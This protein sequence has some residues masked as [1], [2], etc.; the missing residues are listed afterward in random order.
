MS[1]RVILLTLGTDCVLVA[2]RE[3]LGLP[4]PI[5]HILAFGSEFVTVRG[6]RK[7]I[8]SERFFCN[9]FKSQLRIFPSVIIELT[10]YFDLREG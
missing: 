3:I 6:S 9:L 5:K 4:L 10:D 8:R 7:W 2:K 1:G